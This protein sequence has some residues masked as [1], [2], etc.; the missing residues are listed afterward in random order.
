MGST[1]FYSHIKSLLPEKLKQRL[2][3]NSFY[4]AWPG[5]FKRQKTEIIQKTLKKFTKQ[6]KPAIVISQ[7]LWSGPLATVIV[8]C[9]N[10]GS[11]LDAVLSCLEVQTC[12]NFEI[13]LID[14]G[15]TDPETIAR[16]KEL[17][18][19]QQPNLTVMEQPNQGVI[20]ARNNAIAK[21]QGKYIFPLDAD[22]TIEPT[23][24]EKCL[25]YL[26]NSPEHF[27]VYTWTHSTGDKDFTWETRNSDPD[28]SLVENRMGYAL[29]RKSAFMQVGGYNPVMAAG[30]EDWE[31]CVNL[32]AHGYIG[33]V[34]KEPLYNYYVKP[35]AR[36]YHAIKKHEILKE[37]ISNLH[38]STIRTHKRY[39]LKLAQQLYIVQNQLV[40]FFAKG[41]VKCENE[42]FLIDL[43]NSD[44][45]FSVAREK[46]IIWLKGS[47]AIFLVTLKTPWVDYFPVDRPENLYIYYP[48]YYHPDGDVKPFYK[49]LEFY[50]HPQRKNLN[51]LN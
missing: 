2:K 22:D 17:K 36:N 23:F 9:Y 26:E 15:S 28:Y 41:K 29:F 20:A 40:N 47:P 37:K 13:I 51:E 45:D 21:A 46:L 38:R 27:F 39:L 8:T 11:F 25:L 43:Y 24:L 6:S 19:W 44:I 7:Q 32:V 12:Q 14:D 5:F 31:F 1:G 10:Y 16:I 30:Y 3:N 4:K 42:F 35:G 48:E 50:Y 18:K 34:I 49:Y 33:R